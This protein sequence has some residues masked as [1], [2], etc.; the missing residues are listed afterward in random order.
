[1]NLIDELLA[2]YK[3]L[4]TDL[5]SEI[6]FMVL[7]LL[8]NF[9]LTELNERA[10]NQQ[11]IDF[12]SL[13]SQP[14]FSR[15]KVVGLILCL[16]SIINFILKKRSTY[17]GWA[18][19]K[20]FLKKEFQKANSSTKYKELLEDNFSKIDKKAEKWINLSRNWIELENNVF[21]DKNLLTIFHK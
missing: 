7:S 9:K 11:F 3:K 14:R 4:D 5:Q 12:V 15:I 16:R 17:E 21:S 13:Y 20:F 8:P 2:W 19:S 6:A 1:M 18:E 10:I